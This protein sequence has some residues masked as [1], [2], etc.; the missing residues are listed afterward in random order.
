MSHV[1]D[2]ARN[3][4]TVT[5]SDATVLATPTRALYIGGTGALTV[6]MWGSQNNITFSAVP[7]GI[8]PLQVDKI[9]ATGTA[10]TNIVALW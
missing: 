1:S 2:P 4:A 8:F 9:L 5:P 7:V 6:R 10:A 3:A